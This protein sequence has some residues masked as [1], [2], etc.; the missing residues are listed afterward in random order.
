MDVCI[1]VVC[2]YCVLMNGSSRVSLDGRYSVGLWPEKRHMSRALSRMRVSGDG[3]GGAHPRQ[4]R[5][6]RVDSKESS[7]EA[8]GCAAGVALQLVIV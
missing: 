7:T 2:I 6:D 8:N 5:L 3:D 1:I 4:D